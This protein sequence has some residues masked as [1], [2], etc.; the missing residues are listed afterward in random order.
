MK[1][2]FTVREKVLLAILGVLV[3]GALYYYVFYIPTIEDT[4]KYKKDN[5]A[6][7]DQILAVQIQ[8][9]K[10]IQMEKELES[11]KN[12]ETTVSPLPMYDNSRMIMN[13]LNDILGL[14]MEYEVEFGKIEEDQDSNIVRRNV[15][16]FFKTD[17]YNVVKSILTQV[18]YGEYRCVIKDLDISQNSGLY[19]ADVDITY[20]EYKE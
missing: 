6:I 14:T 2:G 10:F 13:E 5:V 9:G 20:F 11:I 12:G 18:N 3:I 7:E 17:S 15:R 19:H 1:K 16:I 8:T 4:E